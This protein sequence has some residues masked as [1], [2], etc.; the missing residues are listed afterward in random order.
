MA[1]T[2][3]GA[4]EEETG[5]AG[6]GQDAMDETEA[7]PMPSEQAQTRCAVV[8]GYRRDVL[9]GGCQNTGLCVLAAGMHASL[10]QSLS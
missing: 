6:G 8:P 4:D 3:L 7:A 10:C 5:P 2:A 9:A 1:A